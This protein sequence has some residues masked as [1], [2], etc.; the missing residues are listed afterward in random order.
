MDTPEGYD[1]WSSR[2]KQRFKDIRRAFEARLAEENE[3]ARLREEAANKERAI[4]AQTQAQSELAT[5]DQWLNR[6]RREKDDEEARFLAE[7]NEAYAQWQVQGNRTEAE[8]RTYRR[9]MKDRLDAHRAEFEAAQD[10]E[11]VRKKE[12]KDVLEAA[13]RRRAQPVRRFPREI[14]QLRQ[15]IR[16]IEERL[17]GM[18]SHESLLL[19]YYRMLEDC[20]PEDPE[21]GD[22]PVKIEPQFDDPSYPPPLRPGEAPTFPPEPN[23]RIVLPRAPKSRLIVGMAGKDVLTF[24]EPGR[25]NRPESVEI[26]QKSNVWHEGCLE[27]I[28]IQ[29]TTPH[30]ARKGISNP[31]SRSVR[32]AAAVVNDI[33]GHCCVRFSYSLKV[34]RVADLGAL[35]NDREHGIFK[36]DE[37]Q[38]VCVAQNAVD[39]PA[40]IALLGRLGRN[41]E[42]VRFLVVDRFTDPKLLGFG[43]GLVGVVTIGKDENSSDRSG[44]TAAHEIGHA[45]AGIEHVDRDGTEVKPHVHGD[46]M[47]GKDCVDHPNAKAMPY[48]RVT[49]LDC[50][51]MKAATR[52]TEEP[53]NHDGV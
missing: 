26:V 9:S 2:C 16:A 28:W 36:D 33:W 25:R 45:L 12:R 31:I 24:R 1:D 51:K 14:E 7:L 35:A 19:D 29:G 10:A 32:D 52:A 5:I 8:H 20:G 46:L 39:R 22:P 43:G 30:A 4:D 48:E 40:L 42:C 6:R 49:E 21:P 37:G 18:P 3:R 34:V 53:C 44:T 41:A 27:F 23:P 15:R 17:I 11:A 13:I 47:W 50:K 38:V